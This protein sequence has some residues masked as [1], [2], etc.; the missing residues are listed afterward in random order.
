M[1]CAR[2]LSMALLVPAA[3]A[4]AARECPGGTSVLEASFSAEGQEWTACEDLRTPGGSL[5]LV[6]THGEVVWQPKTYEPFQQ[7]DDNE[8]YLGL[9]KQNVLD[10]KWDMMGQ[11]IRAI[12]MS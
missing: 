3:A 7:G 12:T 5:V 4:G 6:P 2:L 1:M 9:G 8:Y 10:A 11:A